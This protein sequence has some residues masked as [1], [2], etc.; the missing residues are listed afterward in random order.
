MICMDGS[1]GFLP[2]EARRCDDHLWGLRFA[3]L[4]RPHGVD[5]VPIDDRPMATPPQ[6]EHLSSAGEGSLKPANIDVRAAGAVPRVVCTTVTVDVHDS[7]VC[8]L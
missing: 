4:G 2:M 5:G 6:R 3:S 8:I 7:R 1:L